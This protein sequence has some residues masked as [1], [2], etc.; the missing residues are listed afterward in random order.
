M[1]L[2]NLRSAFIPVIDMALRIAGAVALVAIAGF[3]VWW[4]L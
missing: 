1:G 4:L 3:L 2:E